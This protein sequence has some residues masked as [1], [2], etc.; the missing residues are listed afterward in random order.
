MHV[1]G[2]GGGSAAVFTSHGGIRFS[3]FGFEESPRFTASMLPLRPATANSRAS[4]QIGAASERSERG[5]REWMGHTSFD[6]AGRDYFRFRHSGFLFFGA[7]GT[8]FCDPFGWAAYDQSFLYNNLD[9]GALGCFGQ[10]GYAGL[11]YGPDYDDESA[12]P[13]YSSDDEVVAASPDDPTATA[14]ATPQLTLLQLK[15]GSMYGLTA[16]WVEGG[17]LHYV[18]NYGGA[19][20]IPLDRIDL[21]KTVTLN[22]AR[23]QAFIL[24]AKPAPDKGAH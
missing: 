13:D 24:E 22:A 10:Q 5:N 1:T 20:A 7:F 16:Y 17:E 12:E 2:A 19:N 14:D 18:T 15:D 23:G 8:P 3:D 4:F 21:G 6:H 11:T 9:N